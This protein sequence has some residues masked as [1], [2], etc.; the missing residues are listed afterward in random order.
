VC[1]LPDQISNWQLLNVSYLSSSAL[2]ISMKHSLSVIINETTIILDK[3]HMKV[4]M[5]AGTG[6][7]HIDT[8]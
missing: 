8:Q 6:P 3:T 7:Y 2:D 1:R 4:D 5:T